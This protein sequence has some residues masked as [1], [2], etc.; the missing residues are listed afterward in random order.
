MLRLDFNSFE[1]EAKM[2]ALIIAY[3]LNNETRRPNIV[4]TI[5]DTGS[6]AKLS[7]SS[8]AVD[9]HESPENVM[10]R[11]KKHLDSD[12]NCYV[13]TLSA[14]WSGWGPKEVIAWLSKR[15]GN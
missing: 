2:A 7:E 13:I 6:W 4:K 9:T 14:P 11:L 10:S 1:M 5:K 15:L 12:D 3:D 8:Y